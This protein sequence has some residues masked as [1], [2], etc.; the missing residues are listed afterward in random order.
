MRFI[1]WKCPSACGPWWSGWCRTQ[2]CPWGLFSRYGLSGRTVG[3]WVWRRVP[4]LVLRG[5]RP[6]GSAGWTVRAM[7]G[8]VSPRCP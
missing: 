2:N 7:R 4:V 6:Q 1:S 3:P 5:A 8:T